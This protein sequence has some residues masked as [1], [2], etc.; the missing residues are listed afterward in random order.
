ME[1]KANNPAVLWEGETQTGEPKLTLKVEETLAPGYY[2]VLKNRYKQPGER[3]PDW[4]VMA[5]QQ[6]GQE[7]H[8]YKAAPPPAGAGGSDSDVPF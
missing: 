2:T 5:A 4:K 1:Q 6:D 3:S 8:N 7:R